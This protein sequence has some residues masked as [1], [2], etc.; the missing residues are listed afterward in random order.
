LRRYGRL[1]EPSLPHAKQENSLRE[2][3][4][5][6]QHDRRDLAREIRPRIRHEEVVLREGR[7]PRVRTCDHGGQLRA[8]A[9]WFA[10]DGAMPGE[11]TV[12]GCIHGR[13]GPAPLPLRQGEK[14]PLRCGTGGAKSF[15]P[16]EPS[17]RVGNDGD[18]D[19]NDGGYDHG[20]VDE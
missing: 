3:A 8:E 18:D 11:E 15:G 20:S 7:L 17:R 12:R 1:G 10:L 2:F 4:L 6:F 9:K 16:L 13:V 5:A 19:C 14:K